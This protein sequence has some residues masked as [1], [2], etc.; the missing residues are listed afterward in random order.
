MSVV[1]GD[2]A[3]PWPHRNLSTS[4]PELVHVRSIG[5]SNALPAA[6][7]NSSQTLLTARQS[8]RWPPT[9]RAGRKTSRRP[10]R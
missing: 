3:S 6:T 7:G 9:R 4:P 1:T 8:T 2:A 5:S 10:R